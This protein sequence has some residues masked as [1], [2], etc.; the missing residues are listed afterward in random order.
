MSLT[1]CFYKRKGSCHPSFGNILTLL[2]RVMYALRLSALS[3]SGTYPEEYFDSG[4]EQ[5]LGVRKVQLLNP[6]KTK[7]PL[8]TDEMNR[9]TFTQL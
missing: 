3:A 7:G 1:A 6:A 8:Y 2:V 5:Y 9:R 4:Y